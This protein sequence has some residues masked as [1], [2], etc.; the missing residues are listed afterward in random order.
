MWVDEAFK[1]CIYGFFVYFPLSHPKFRKV[2]G[3]MLLCLG[4]VL[5]MSQGEKKK[6]PARYFPTWVYFQMPKM[7]LLPPPEIYARFPGGKK[8]TESAWEGKGCAL[9]KIRDFCA[10][11]FFCPLFPG[12]HLKK[13]PNISSSSEMPVPKD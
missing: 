3:H 1:I 6:L 7:P 2:V 4:G 12:L 9:R 11:L 10:P 13:W 8:R 5:N